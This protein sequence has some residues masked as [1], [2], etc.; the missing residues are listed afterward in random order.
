MADTV[1][2]A[3]D[4]GYHAGSVAVAAQAAG[5]HPSTLS[6]RTDL[7]LEPGQVIRDTITGLYGTVSYVTI[8]NIRRASA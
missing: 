2:L 8:Q 5:A 4:F 1:D 7:D 3:H 6:S